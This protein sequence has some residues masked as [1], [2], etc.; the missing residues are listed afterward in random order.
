M[1]FNRGSLPWQGLKVGN[2]G[3]ENTFFI[4]CIGK[5]KR[6]IFF[7]ILDKNFTFDLKLLE[8]RTFRNIKIC[9]DATS[10]I[11]GHFYFHFFTFT[12]T[13]CNKETEIREDQ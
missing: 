6:I 12:F 11:C 3:S 7:K 4:V 9:A 8:H 1:Y 2:I 10:M 5:D 13:G